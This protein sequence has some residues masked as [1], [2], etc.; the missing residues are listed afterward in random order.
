[1]AQGQVL[2]GELAVAA[3]QEGEESKE[4]EQ[5]RIIELGLCPDQGRQINHLPPAEVLAKD[6]LPEGRERLERLYGLNRELRGS[7]IPLGELQ[8]QVETLRELEAISERLGDRRRLAQVLP[9]SVYT[10]GALGD[11]RGAIQAAQRARALA[12]EV[13]DVP[14]RVGAD[15]MVARAY[16][17]LG[18]HQE[19][20]EAAERALSELPGEL[21]Y[22]NLFPVGL[23]QSVGARV[24]KGMALAE[25]GNF[26]SAKASLE[27]AMRIADADE[28]PHERVWA[29]F[30]CGRVAFVQGDLHR[31]TSLLEPI[32]PLALGNARRRPDHGRAGD[33]RARSRPGRRP[34]S[35]GPSRQRWD[36]R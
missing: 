34:R 32:L 30:G 9:S 15:A 11:H 7:L 33:K 2:E 22:R 20:I 17:A 5:E 8:R 36:A 19:A 25:Q 29:R 12:E 21:S 10:L 4:V 23:L 35:A 6:N 24:W 27:E 31:A 1:V 18:Q 28:G 3:E 26:A 14:A 16:Y 13:G